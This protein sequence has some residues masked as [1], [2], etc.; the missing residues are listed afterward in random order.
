MGIFDT[1]I[2]D[3]KT[4]SLLGRYAGD[5]SFQTK[6][7]VEDGRILVYD[8]VLSARLCCYISAKINLHV[9]P[10]SP[11]LLAEE[12]LMRTLRLDELGEADLVSVD[13]MA[14]LDT[15]SLDLLDKALGEMGFKKIVD[16]EVENLNKIEKAIATIPWS[17]EDLPLIISRLKSPQPPTHKQEGEEEDNIS[18]L[19]RLARR[20][21][22]SIVSDRVGVIVPYGAK[23]EVT[24]SGLRVLL[25]EYIRVRKRRVEWGLTTKTSGGYVIEATISY[26]SKE[27]NNTII[28]VVLR[29]PLSPSLEDAISQAIEWTHRLLDKLMTY[30]K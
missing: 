11:D 25:E 27:Y 18:N 1:V 20:P 17:N 4:A 10:R 16:E 22:V 15:S 8:V 12:P 6:Y 24:A 19:L 29:Q 13:V 3:D 14:T 26:R 30:R 23:L 21:R 28:N 2:L 5:K 9:K 7:V